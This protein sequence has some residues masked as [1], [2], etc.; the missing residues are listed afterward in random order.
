[1]HVKGV[2]LAVYYILELV[3]DLLFIQYMFFVHA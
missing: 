1:M 2:C 3:V